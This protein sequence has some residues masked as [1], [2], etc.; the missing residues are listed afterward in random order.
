MR[1]MQQAIEELIVTAVIL[2]QESQHSLRYRLLDQV[3]ALEAI[4]KARPR[5]RDRRQIPIVR[6]SK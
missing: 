6:C 2:A 3:L 4:V 1:D 5:H